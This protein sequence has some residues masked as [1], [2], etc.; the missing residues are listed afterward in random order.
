VYTFLPALSQLCL[1]LRYAFEPVLDVANQG[2]LGV[3][4]PL[5]SMNC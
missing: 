2:R 4:I 1:G 3:G 5:W